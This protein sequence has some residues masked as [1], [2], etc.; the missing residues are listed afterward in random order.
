MRNTLPRSFPTSFIWTH[1]SHSP[2]MR[3]MYDTRVIENNKKTGIPFSGTPAFAH[4]T[5]TALSLHSKVQLVAF[6]IDQ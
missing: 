4:N 5:L 2:A 3:R 1:V 6:A